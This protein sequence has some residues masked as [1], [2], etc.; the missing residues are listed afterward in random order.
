MTQWL[1]SPVLKWQACIES[2]ATPT[3]LSTRTRSWR[4]YHFSTKPSH[5]SPRPTQNRVTNASHSL[6]PSV[7]KYDEEGSAILII[8]VIEWSITSH[9]F[10][11]KEILSPKSSHPLNFYCCT[12]TSLHITQKIQ[13]VISHFHLYHFYNLLYCELFCWS[14]P[15]AR[16]YCAKDSLKIKRPRLFARM[17][18]F[19]RNVQNQHISYKVEGRWMRRYEIMCCYRSQTKSCV[20]WNAKGSRAAQIK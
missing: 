20:S 3:T 7:G 10:F 6:F 9:T 19:T 5:D 4:L 15:I 16:F 2:A 17:C 1:I 13:L 8:W 12:V 18:L 11:H 14:I